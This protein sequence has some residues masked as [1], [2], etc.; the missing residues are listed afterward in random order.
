MTAP[1][2]HRSEAVDALASSP[3]SIG[4]RVAVLQSLS[5]KKRWS[6]FTDHFLI[7]I[8][9]IVTICCLLIWLTMHILNP[10]AGPK[11][12]VALVDH[13]IE[14]AE[15][16]ELNSQAATALHMQA[17]D[18]SGLVVDDGFDFSR[19]GLPKL[20]TMLSAGT[21]DVII[22]PKSTFSRL[23]SYGY[24]TDLSQILPGNQFGERALLPGPGNDSQDDE[25]E[26][27][28]GKGPIKPYG[29]MC[30]SI[31]NQR[32]RPHQKKVNER[33]GFAKA[34]S[35]SQDQAIIG[36]A[37]NSPHKQDAVRFTKFACGR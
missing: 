4:G 29:L 2:E 27:P 25:A 32:W 30:G 13:P 7:L 35:T 20:Q 21:V 10:A 15:T 36:L 8:I 6:Y 37:V 5:G 18:N 28:M 34:K 33:H 17:D 26:A 12:F 11:L 14:S 1:N 22:A 19:D 16:G 23:A 31:Q 3:V 9:A 24:M